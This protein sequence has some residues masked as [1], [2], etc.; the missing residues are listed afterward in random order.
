MSESLS[1]VEKFVEEVLIDWM[2]E[3]VMLERGVSIGAHA[4]LMRGL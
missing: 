1:V 2:I 4:Y 3:R